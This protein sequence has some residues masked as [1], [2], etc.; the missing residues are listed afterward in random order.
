MGRYANRGE[1]D[2]MTVV[3]DRLDAVDHEVGIL[4]AELA[5]SVPV[6]VIRGVVSAVG[7]DLEGQVP[8]DAFP[9]FLHRSAVQRLIDRRGDDR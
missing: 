6:D 5:G 8:V 2:A 1:A 9:E 3:D 4:M 7:K